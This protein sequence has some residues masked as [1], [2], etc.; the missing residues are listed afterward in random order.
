MSEIEKKHFDASGEMSEVIASRLGNNRGVHPETV[1][2]AAARMAGTMLFR[3]FGIDTS[4]ME[5]GSVILSEE[6]NENG[7]R[8]IHILG[9]MLNNYGLE[10][11]REKLAD[12]ENR[13]D[14]PS[15]SILET[16]ELL[17]EDFTTIC[18][19]NNLSS[20]EAADA[21]A[22]L[23]AWLIKECAPQIGLEAGFNLAVYSFIEGAKTVPKSDDSKS[24]DKPKRPWY[25][26]FG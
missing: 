19:K 17:A 25:K 8:L 2:A 16:Q 22:L 14:E 6:A 26:I 1:I 4:G 13:G 20:S 15:L 21:C 3:S 9:G 23:T 24:N 18:D 11:N 5:A 7:P 12:A 10:P